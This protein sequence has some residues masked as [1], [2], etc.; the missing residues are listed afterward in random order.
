VPARCASL[1]LPLVDI[2]PAAVSAAARVSLA[3]DCATGRVPQL[4]GAFA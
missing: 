3:L 4:A 2:D 1:D